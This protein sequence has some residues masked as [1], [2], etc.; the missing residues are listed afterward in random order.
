MKL[1][2]S[3]ARFLATGLGVG[4]C[5]V[6]GVV[7]VYY[8]VIMAWS[9]YYFMKSLTTGPLPWATC[10]NWWNTKNC[11]ARGLTAV[12]AYSLSLFFLLLYCFFFGILELFAV[13]DTNFL[14]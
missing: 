2:Y 14:F 10:D 4:M 11:S 5:L 9:V 12:V 6:S 8:N 1:L 3:D 13:F 7:C